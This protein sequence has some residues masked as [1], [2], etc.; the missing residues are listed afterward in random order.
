[1]SISTQPATS[2]TESSSAWIPPELVSL[3]LA[4]LWEEPH[5]PEERSALLKSIVFVNRTWLALVA[6]IASRDVHV[7]NERN[8]C[9][10]LGLLPKRS[11]YS[12]LF[13]RDV[14]PFANENCRS[15]T[16][17]VKNRNTSKS[18]NGDLGSKDLCTPATWWGSQSDAAIAILLS[19]IY[20]FHYLPNL[21]HVLFRYTDWAYDDVFLQLERMLF[22]QQATHLSV[23]YSFTTPAWALALNESGMVARWSRRREYPLAPSVRHLSLSGVTTVFVATML[24]VCPNVET[25]E[26]THP[27]GLDALAPL[28]P[29][30]RTLV[31]RYPGVAVSRKTMMSWNLSAALEDGLFPERKGKKPRIVVRSGTPEVEP[32][33]ELRRSCKGFN[34]D[35]VYERDDARGPS[36]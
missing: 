9:A 30:V 3:I 7:S 4:M 15:L 1:M 28:L 24:P 22:P 20:V 17:H 35:L 10:F 31:L 13:I 12:D 29:A 25:V 5:S 32:F 16:F 19:T 33:I 23:D 2:S 6:P 14:N 34:V 36:C 18:P 11:L 8:A 27:A 21:R 26:I